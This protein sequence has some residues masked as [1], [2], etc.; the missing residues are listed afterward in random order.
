MGGL[1]GPLTLYLLSCTPTCL[2]QDLQSASFKEQTNV[3]GFPLQARQRAPPTTG[4]CVSLVTPL[5]ARGL[6]RCKLTP[7]PPCR[8]LLSFQ[9]YYCVWFVPLERPLP[10]RR[11]I[12]GPGWLFPAG[13]TC[14]CITCLRGPG[15]DYFFPGGCKFTP[16]G[17]SLIIHPC[18]G[19]SI[20]CGQCNAVR[21][22]VGRGRMDVA[23][24]ADKRST[25][26]GQCSAKG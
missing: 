7:E 3:R 5:P 4:S 1:C 2:N 11:G 8:V 22:G 24:A 25:S 14:L 12:G 26:C 19:Q 10:H 21:S 23:P 6:G 20:N 15:A 17:K 18:R 13:K 16:S 9:P